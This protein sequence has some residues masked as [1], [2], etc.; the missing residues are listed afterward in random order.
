MH[1]YRYRQRCWCPA[2][3]QLSYFGA[4]S[5]LISVRQHSKSSTGT[6]TNT[7]I[8]LGPYCK[9]NPPS[10]GR[11]SKLRAQSA[12]RPAHVDAVQGNVRLLRRNVRWPWESHHRVQTNIKMVQQLGKGINSVRSW[13]QNRRGSFDPA[14]RRMVLPSTVFHQH[15]SFLWILSLG[16]VEYVNDVCYHSLIA[17]LFLFTY[18]KQ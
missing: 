8:P 6:A 2:D 4:H 15:F 5:V 1:S 16:N 3:G 10:T 14:W 11:G 12:S 13:S 9:A 7:V 17:N 18:N